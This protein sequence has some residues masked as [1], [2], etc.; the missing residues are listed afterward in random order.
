MS[1]SRVFALHV[2][3]TVH[4]GFFVGRD[5]AF[6]RSVLQRVVLHHSHDGGHSHTVVGTEGRALGL[7]PFT[8]DKSF[9]GV[10]FK[11]CACCP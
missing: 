7:Y 5:K 11:N 6:D 10:G 9:D 3:H 4:G 2:V 1:P 8:V